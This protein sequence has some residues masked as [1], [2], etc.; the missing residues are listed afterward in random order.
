MKLGISDKP[1]IAVDMKLEVATT[2]TQEGLFLETPTI[3]QPDN[4]LDKRIKNYSLRHSYTDFWRDFT[5]A[6]IR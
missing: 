1:R 5:E 2:Y 6:S 3:P 4:P